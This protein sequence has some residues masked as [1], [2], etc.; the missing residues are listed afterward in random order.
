MVAALPILTG[1][2]LLLAFLNFDIH[3]EPSRAIYPN[4][5]S[6]SAPGNPDAIS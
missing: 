4:L 2:Q 5:Q 1:I 3:A 6:T